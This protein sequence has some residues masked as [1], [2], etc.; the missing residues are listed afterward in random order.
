MGTVFAEIDDELAGWIRSQQLFFVGTAPSGDEG[1]VN[2]SPKG[3]LRTFAILGPLKL[4]YVDLFGSGIETV[5][6]LKQNGRIVVMFCAFTGPPRV[7][8]L[9][10]KGRVVEQH[11]PEFAELSAGFA[12]TDEVTPS[13]RSIIVIDIERIADSCG[14]VVPKMEPQGERGALYQTAAGWIRKRGPSAIPDYCDV[15]NGESIDG[16]PGLTPFGA[17]LTD[18]QKERNA[19][20]GRRL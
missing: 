11:E 16:F 7:L 12:L 13:V 8:R 20:A 14:Y 17:K 4:A 15:N 6:H 9:H 18:D 2:I 5:A 19:S 10:G 1:H 3:D